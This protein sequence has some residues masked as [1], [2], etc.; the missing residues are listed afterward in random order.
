M[1]VKIYYYESW[2]EYAVNLYNKK[3]Q[4][5]LSTILPPTHDQLDLP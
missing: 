4:L 5:V 1:E 2:G 3:G